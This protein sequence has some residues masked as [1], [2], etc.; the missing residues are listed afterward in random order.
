MVLIM[1]K[2]VINV[3]QETLRYEPFYVSPEG[4]QIKESPL[5]GRTGQ[6]NTQGTW[7]TWAQMAT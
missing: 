2:I 5:A 7:H 6:L 1:A 3:G 4:I